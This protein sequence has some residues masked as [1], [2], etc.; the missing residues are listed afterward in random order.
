MHLEWR[1]L[2]YMWYW[3][4]QDGVLSCPASHNSGQLGALAIP[5]RGGAIGLRLGYVLEDTERCP[6]LFLWPDWTLS[7]WRKSQRKVDISE[8]Y[9]WVCRDQNWVQGPRD[10]GNIVKRCLDVFHALGMA[11]FWQLLALQHEF[12]SCPAS[13]HCEQLGAPNVPGRSEA[14]RLRFGY[15]LGNTKHCST[16]SL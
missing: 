11:R 10:L 7:S 1:D 13:P 15:V 16:L 2:I 12:L 3:Q 4:L 8:H 5:G 9:F 6:T 14:I